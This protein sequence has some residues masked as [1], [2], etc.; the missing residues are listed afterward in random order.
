MSGGFSPKV[1]FPNDFKVQTQSGEYQK[2]FYFGASQ[3]P[4]NLG[5]KHSS[6]SGSGMV[7][8]S[9]DPTVERKPFHL[10]R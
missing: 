2:P 9:T 5:L 6:F 10:P 8:T 4:V 3:V 1:L 7:L